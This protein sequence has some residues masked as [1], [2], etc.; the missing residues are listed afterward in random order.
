MRAA[1]GGRIIQ[2]SLNFGGLVALPGNSLYHESK[3]GLEGFSESL[4][5]EV[6]PFGIG[7][8]I[9]EPGGARTE[10][11][12]ASAQVAWNACRNTRAHLRARSSDA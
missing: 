5:Q 2:M 3:S 7:V 12:Y 4:A 6:A 1:G 10:F 11:R 8:T 9:V